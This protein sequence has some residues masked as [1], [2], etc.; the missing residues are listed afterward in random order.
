MSS[1]DALTQPRSLK[2]GDDMFDG[3]EFETKIGQYGSAS[4]DLTPE[5]KLK[6]N[7]E[8]TVDL[9]VEAKKLA[10]KTKTPL[11]EQALRWLEI[12]VGKAS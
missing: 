6:L 11:D 2:Q 8:L 5:L 1:T 4:V 10:A 12:L 3:K 9:V 7:F